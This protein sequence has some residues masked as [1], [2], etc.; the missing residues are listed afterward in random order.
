MNTLENFFNSKIYQQMHPKKKAVIKELLSN[1]NGKKPTDCLPYLMNA[2]AQLKRMN[3][4]FTSEESAQIFLLL[5]ADMPQETRNKL[6]SILKI[7]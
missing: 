5:T 7:M 6:S 1:I 2:N 3:M 4:S